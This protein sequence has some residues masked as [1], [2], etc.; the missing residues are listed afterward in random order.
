MP[1]L[2]PTDPSAHVLAHPSNADNA[3][4]TTQSERKEATHLVNALQGHLG[5]SSDTKRERE[6]RKRVY[7]VAESGREASGRRRDGVPMGTIA[8]LDAIGEKS[9]K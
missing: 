4:P 5:G 9:S 3:Q 7:W 1:R 2:K 6:E 8:G